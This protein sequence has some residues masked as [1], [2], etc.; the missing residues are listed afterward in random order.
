MDPTSETGIYVDLKQKY[1]TIYDKLDSMTYS[2][3]KN[4]TINAYLEDMDKRT[5]RKNMEYG[6]WLGLLVAAGITTV[7]LIKD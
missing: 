6:L 3:K 5:P 1:K 7:T 4:A 2:E